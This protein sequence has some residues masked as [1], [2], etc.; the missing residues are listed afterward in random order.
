MTR[1]GVISKKKYNGVS[2][3]IGDS[4]RDPNLE[5]LHGIKPHSLNLPRQVC[6][7]PIANPGN[8]KKAQHNMIRLGSN[9][10]LKP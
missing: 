5:T 10:E 1:I 8:Q 6:N 4:K 9:K 7:I 3:Y 2:Y